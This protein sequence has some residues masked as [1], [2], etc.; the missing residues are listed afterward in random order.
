MEVSISQVEK[1]RI[2]G[3]EGLDPISVIFED[4]G[5]GQGKVTIEIYGEAWSHYWGAMGEQHKVKSFFASCND[6][7][8]ALKFIRGP[9]L[10]PDWDEITDRLREVEQDEDITVTC[11]MECLDNSE[12][13]QNAYGECWM[14]ELPDRP[15]RERTYLNQICRAIKQ[16]L[17]VGRARQ[18]ATTQ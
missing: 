5:P 4:F 7:Y 17:A 2:T 3:A 13:M 15:T 11:E 12:A 10:E 14:V 8:L 6:D 16:A 9:S 18:P 1:M